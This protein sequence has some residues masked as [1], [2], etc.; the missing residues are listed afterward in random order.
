MKEIGY[1]NSYDEKDNGYPLTKKGKCKIKNIIKKFALI[2]FYKF[3]V[4]KNNKNDIEK[5][6]TMF[7]FKKP[8]Y[9]EVFN[10]KLDDRHYQTIFQ[11]FDKVLEW[12]CWTNEE[13][14]F[15][16]NQK[17]AALESKKKSNLHYY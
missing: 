16:I 14:E 4:E 5:Q 1:Y 10:N 8:G 11:V 15:I 9:L 17:N 13:R 3:L 6:M 2:K 12:N 7:F